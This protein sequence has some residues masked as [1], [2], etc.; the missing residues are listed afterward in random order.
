MMKSSRIDSFSLCLLSKILAMILLICSVT[1]SL[2]AF[3]SISY[4]RLYWRSSTP[5]AVN[6]LCILEDC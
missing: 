2:D 6:H 5:K 4:K 1:S 3:A